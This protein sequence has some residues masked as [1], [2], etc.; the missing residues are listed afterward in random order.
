MNKK[1][2]LG[3]LCLYSFCLWQCGQSP[4][5]GLT[6][7]TPQQRATQALEN[8][9]PDDAINIMLDAL[10]TDIKNAFTAAEDQKLSTASVT[11]LQ[12]AVDAKIASGERETRN[13]LS[14][15]ASAVAQKNGIDPFTLAIKLAQSGSSTSST[16]TSTTTTSSQSQSNFF[17]LMFPLLPEATTEHRTAIQMTTTILDTIGQD[18]LTKE[19]L[20]KQA[21]F[22]SA[23]MAMQFKLLDKNGD[24]VISLDEAGNLDESSA[25]EIIATLASTSDAA[26]LLQKLQDSGIAGTSDISTASTTTGQSTGTVEQIDKL[27]AAIEAQPGADT[28]EKLQN[29]ITSTNAK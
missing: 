17:T 14:I 12:A 2:Q 19:D 22:L 7:S 10:G 26:T 20:F 13:W 27:K 21:L 15:L 25:D 6:K 5:A 29:Y 23:S 24:G 8:Q 18:H 28:K 3:F 11:S 1:Y 16:A 4:F 9:K